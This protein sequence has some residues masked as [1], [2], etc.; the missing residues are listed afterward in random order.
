V[1]NA[2]ANL[3]TEGGIGSKVAQFRVT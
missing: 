1:D 2:T 3:L